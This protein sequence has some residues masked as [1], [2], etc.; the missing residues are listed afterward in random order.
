MKGRGDKQ[1]VPTKPTFGY[2]STRPPRMVVVRKRGAFTRD[3]QT[4]LTFPTAE[5]SYC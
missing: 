5:V 4:K 1:N 3:A 2:M